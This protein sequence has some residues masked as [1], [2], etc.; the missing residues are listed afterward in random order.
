M[1]FVKIYAKNVKFEYLNPILGKL[2][3]MHDLGWWLVGKSMVDFLFALIELHSLSITVPELWGKTIIARLFSQRDRPVCTQILPGHGHPP[4]TILGIG[5]L[6][7][8]GYMTV[9]IAS[10]CF[11]SFWHNTECD[12]QTDKWICCS[13]PGYTAFAN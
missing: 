5:T 6:E 1:F 8:L 2:G 13:I 9:K 4:S 7:T 10:R 12:G 3:V 11:P